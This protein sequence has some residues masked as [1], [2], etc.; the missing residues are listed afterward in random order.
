LLFHCHI[1]Y[2]DCVSTS[3]PYYLLNSL[4]RRCR[5]VWINMEHR[6]MMRRSQ[7]FGRFPAED[8]SNRRSDFRG[9]SSFR[10]HKRRA[11][12]S[13]K[14]EQ[15]NAES[16]TLTAASSQQQQQLRVQEITQSHCL[17]Q[18]F[19]SKMRESG[20]VT[21]AGYQAVLQDFVASANRTRQANDAA[22]AE[23]MKPSC[24]TA[25]T[26][27][28]R[29]AEMLKARKSSSRRS[30]S[31]W[32]SSRRF[33]SFLTACAPSC[34]DE[35]FAF[36]ND[37]PETTAASATTSDGRTEMLNVRRRS[38]SRRGSSRLFGS[39]FTAFAGDNYDDFLDRDNSNRETNDYEANIAP[40]KRSVKATQEQIEYLQN[41]VNEYD[42]SSH[43]WSIASSLSDSIHVNSEYDD[44]GDR[45]R[46]EK[47]IE[48]DSNKSI[49]PNRDTLNLEENCFRGAEGALGISSALPIPSQE[50]S[51]SSDEAADVTRRNFTAS[52]NFVP[53][54]SNK[55]AA[56]KSEEQCDASVEQDPGTSASSDSVCTLDDCVWLPWPEQSGSIIEDKDDESC[57]TGQPL[58]DDN[59]L[60]W[61]ET[62]RN[63]RA[64]A[65]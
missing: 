19:L 62:P 45:E 50:Q 28:D 39:F 53:A 32:G 1:L 43:R 47:R 57:A 27:I 59:F 38:S 21:S 2:T 23:N 15:A 14:H 58:Y 22:A 11:S 12:S 52:V 55:N 61:P 4:A 36:G 48:Y 33:S 42:D 49:L 24:A 9:S 30:S 46:L 51:H 31:G 60:P 35:D 56:P 3:I 26:K 6:A 63:G 13:M 37:A 44:E 16:S 10:F 41:I 5:L 64:L 8:S 20:V 29:R 25:S 54:E 7:S 17:E 18:R 65:A 40:L 34:D